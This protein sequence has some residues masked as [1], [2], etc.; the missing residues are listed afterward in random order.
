M[1]NEKWQQK[2]VNRKF[3][4]EMRIISDVGSL[5]TRD[6]VVNDARAVERQ[7]IRLNENIT[8]NRMKLYGPPAQDVRHQIV[9]EGKKL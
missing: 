2:G 4:E 3:I 6:L 7:V 8:L 9:A 1:P 5:N